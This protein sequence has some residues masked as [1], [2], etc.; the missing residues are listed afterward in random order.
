MMATRF[1]LIFFSPKGS[2]N[3]VLSHLFAKHP[4]TVG[5]IGNYQSCAF[6]TSG[7]GQFRHTFMWTALFWTRCMNVSR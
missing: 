4:E 6:V 1:K 7:I 2:T 5:K 3:T